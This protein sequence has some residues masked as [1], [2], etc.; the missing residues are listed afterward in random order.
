VTA[1]EDWRK[2]NDDSKNAKKCDVTSLEGL[3]VSFLT[4]QEDLF[5]NNCSHK[6][7]S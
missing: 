3:M 4:C 1:F 7:K 6:T 5:K 2:E